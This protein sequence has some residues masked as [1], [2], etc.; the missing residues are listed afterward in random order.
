MPC[1]PVY[2]Y[3]SE[4]GAH[5]RSNHGP[6]RLMKQELLLLHIRALAAGSIGRIPAGHKRCAV[7]GNVPPFE[8][9]IYAVRIGIYGTILPPRIYSRIRV[10]VTEIPVHGYRFDAVAV[11]IIL[12]HGMRSEFAL[13]LHRIP[14]QVLEAVTFIVRNPDKSNLSSDMIIFVPVA[15]STQVP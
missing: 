5:G 2:W 12:R 13:V 14:M 7:L 4:N 9:Y 1:R 10:S 11:R 6:E 8:S 3:G 15:S